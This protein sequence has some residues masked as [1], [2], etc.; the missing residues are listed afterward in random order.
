MDNPPFF[1][2]H[3]NQDEETRSFRSKNLLR[4]KM[5]TFW[6]DRLVEIRNS[7]DVCYRHL[8]PFAR[9]RKIMKSDKRVKMI[10]ADTP[11]LFAKAC[12]IFILELTLRAWMNTED[13]NRQALQRCDVVEAVM[14]EELLSFLAKIVS[15]DRDQKETAAGDTHQCPAYPMNLHNLNSAL[16]MRSQEV[17]QHPVFPPSF[18]SAEIN[19]QQGYNVQ[20][21]ADCPRGTHHYPVYPMNLHN[22]NSALH[23]RSYEVPQHHVFP[24]SFSSAETNYRQ[25]FNEQLVADCPGDTREYPAYPMS[26]HNLNSALLVRSQEGPQHLVFPPQFSSSETNNLPDLNR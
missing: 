21:V 10:T 12:E 8:L 1:L 4:L 5:L 23:T 2:G 18:S 16:L 26:L 24:P 11:I 20:T 17:P 15:F 7:R 25:G 3:I 13:S 9:I 19:Y 6:K 14:G 22:L